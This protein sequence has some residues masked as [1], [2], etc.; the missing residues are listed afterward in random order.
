MYAYNVIKIEEKN[1]FYFISQME[2]DATKCDL[3]YKK[4]VKLFISK[5][6]EKKYFMWG[7]SVI[8]RVV[9]LKW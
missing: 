1:T 2:L 8:R 3:Y 9:V 7:F 6:C 4:R 5:I